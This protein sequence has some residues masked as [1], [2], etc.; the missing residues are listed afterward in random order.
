MKNT[1]NVLTSNLAVPFTLKDALSLKTKDELHT[2]RRNYGIEKASTLNKVSLVDLLSKEIPKRLENLFLTWD[3]QRMNILKDL[4]FRNGKVSAESLESQQIY[5]FQDMGFIFHV[6]DEGMNKLALPSDS[7][8]S[9]RLK[10]LLNDTKWSPIVKQN[11]EWIK[12]VN[13]LLFYYGTLS[14]DQFFEQIENGLIDMKEFR[15]FLDTIFEAKTYYE[16]INHDE[17][18]FSHYEVMDPEM[19]LEQQK[20]RPHLNF[21]PFT[22][23]QLICAG[24]EDY[25]ERT[26]SFKKVSSLLV[27]ECSLSKKEADFM[28]EECQS[29]FKQGYMPNEVLKAWTDDIVF[30]SMDSA[31]KVIDELMPF[32]NN[33]K[34]WFLKGYAPSEIRSVKPAA[35]PTRNNVISFES[36]KKVGRNDPCPCGSG[37]KFK[38]CCGD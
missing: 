8:L 11:T 2:L 4:V 29:L 21:Y 30:E 16:Y 19:V 32:Y 9:E 33:T 23:K 34:Q 20:L 13:G 7:E 27:K 35:E 24:D 17:N 22:K 38:K 36:G 37:K 14:A 31:K 28:T 18:G 6:S 25:V 26:P 10:E 15:R 3:E 12:V 1:M 5:F